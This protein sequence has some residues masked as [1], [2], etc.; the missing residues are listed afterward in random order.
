MDADGRRRCARERARA[1]G[2]EKGGKLVR[3]GGGEEPERGP[4]H[5]GEL[6]VLVC[7]ESCCLRGGEREREGREPGRG[8]RRE[9]SRMQGSVPTAAIACSCL[10]LGDVPVKPAAA[11]S[12]LHCIEKHGR[13]GRARG[14]FRA[15][16]AAVLGRP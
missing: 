7:G 13:N 10:A 4:R 6:L 11:S 14:V 8:P 9:M 3:H 2:R 15:R 1:R 16:G 12:V 5:E